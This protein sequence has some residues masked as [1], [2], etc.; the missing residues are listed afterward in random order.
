MTTE[1]DG[2]GRIAAERKRQIE[3]EGWTG[4]HDDGHPPGDFAL[5]AICYAAPQHVYVRRDCAQ[6][7]MFDDP[8]PWLPEWDKR[9][10]YEDGNT[11][12]DPATF[13]PEKRLDLL[14]KAGALIAAEIDRLLR[15]EEPET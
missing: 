2:A 8:W 6:T 3:A 13:D 7:I 15:Q 14:V 11:Q 9:P 5:A 4:E 10:E 12:P 1:L